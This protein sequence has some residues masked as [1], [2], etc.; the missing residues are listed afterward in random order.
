MNVAHL[1]SPADVAILIPRLLGRTPR[2]ELIGISLLRARPLHPCLEAD[3]PRRAG[4]VISFRTPQIK[5]F[6][7]GGT[8]KFENIAQAGPSV[9]SLA[10][11][12]QAFVQNFNVQLL[13]VVWYCDEVKAALL[14]QKFLEI[15]AAIRALRQRMKRR[16]ENGGSCGGGDGK[17]EETLQ[18]RFVLTDYRQWCEPEFSSELHSFAKLCAGVCARDLNAPGVCSADRG[19]KLLEYAFTAGQE[20]AYPQLI[21]TVHDKYRALATSETKGNVTMWNNSL[22]SILKSANRIAQESIA[23]QGKDSDCR[24]CGASEQKQLSTAQLEAYSQLWRECAGSAARI[25]KLLKQLSYHAV[26]DRLLLFA[27][28]PS[29]DSAARINDKELVRLM[30]KAAKQ[31][32]KYEKVMQ[33]TAWL[34]YLSAWAVPGDDSIYAVMAYTHW[35]A[36]QGTQ[37]KLALERAAQ[38]CAGAEAS[39]LAELVGYA[40]RVQLPPPWV[41]TVCH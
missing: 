14:S 37:A 34:A 29:L 38:I 6:N 5:A 26:R 27:L 23:Q 30:G 33:V 16:K 9:E 12:L 41:D 7:D 1:Q 4:P 35:W 39:S 25:A 20:A 13:A 8:Q 28:H 15:M 18:V 19:I 24:F 22:R 36:G 21:K 40:L 2:E 32:P 3:D 31:P 10:I 17:V 11:Q